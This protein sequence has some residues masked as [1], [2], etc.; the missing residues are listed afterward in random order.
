MNAS[1]N[2]CILWELAN[3]FRIL[4]L[5]LIELATPPV[6]GYRVVGFFNSTSQHAMEVL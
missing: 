1:G 4:L 3:Y 5:L 2:E 6:R